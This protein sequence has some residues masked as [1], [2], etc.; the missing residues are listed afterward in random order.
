MQLSSDY[1][2]HG[3]FIA[4]LIGAESEEYQG[5]AKDSRLL[6]Y[7]IFTQEGQASQENLAKGIN[8]A[9][10]DGADIINLSLS[11]PLNLEPG[12]NLLQ[13]LDCLLYTS[14][15]IKI[16]YAYIIK[17]NKFYVKQVVIFKN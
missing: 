6:I 11:L 15:L 7:Q 5:L 3:T 2:G 9:L 17:H 1:L 16:F 12:A 13:A 10:A 4:G 8:S 14:I